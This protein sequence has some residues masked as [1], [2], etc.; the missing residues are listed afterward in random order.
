MTMKPFTRVESVAVPMPND[1]IDTDI[2]FPA[3]FLTLTGKLGLGRYAFHDKRYDEHGAELAAF[4]LN[5][6][7]YREAAI[8]VAGANFGCG[9]SREQAP[10]ALADFGI[11]CVIA[12]GFGAIFEANCLR[13]GMLPV[14]LD[15]AHHARVMQSAQGGER[16][17]VDLE[18]RQVV[19]EAGEPIAFR[20]DDD[21]R[22]ALLEGRDEIDTILRDSSAAIALFEARQRVAMPWL[23][24]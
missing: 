11:R 18:R 20:I 9:S 12:P 5:R 14:R 4:V 7:P 15:A 3:R 8:L 13:N 22:L 6:P 19:L 23:H 21:A 24:D 16:V 10:W 1:D 2:I 17:I